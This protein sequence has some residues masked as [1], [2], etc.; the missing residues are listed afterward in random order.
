MQLPLVHW[1]AAAQGTPLVNLAVQTPLLHQFP[2]PQ[3]ASTRQVT[4]RPSATRQVGPRRVMP[5]PVQLAL[6]VH[7]SQAP[8]PRQ[9]GA[10]VS[11]QG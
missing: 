2:A 6:T 9:V 3:S 11:R 8:V 1:F 5:P 4:Q 7:T 10:L